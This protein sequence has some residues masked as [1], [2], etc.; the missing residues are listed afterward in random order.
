MTLDLLFLQQA[1]DVAGEA[2]KVTDGNILTIL[3]SI[4]ATIFAALTLTQRSQVDTLQKVIADCRAGRDTD[5]AYERARAAAAE[6]KEDKCLDR[7]PTFIEPMTALASAVK[8]NATVGTAIVQEVRNH[9]SRVDAIV[10]TQDVISRDISDNKKALDD[11]KRALDDVRYRRGP[12][13][14]GAPTER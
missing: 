7:L 1:A 5:I 10:R 11:V 12:G 14:N 3:A 8:E 9:A 4:I 13:G 6:A 2:S